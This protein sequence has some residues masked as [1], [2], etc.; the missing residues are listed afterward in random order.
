AHLLEEGRRGG[1]PCDCRQSCGIHFASGSGRSWKCTA[2]GF[3]PLPP[4]ISHGARAP[5]DV[6]SPRPFPPAL[7]SSR[8][9]SHPLASTP[10]GYGTRREIILPSLSATSPSMR[11]AVD[12]GTSLPSPNV[13]CWS[14]Q[15]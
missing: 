10:R 7:R 4:S 11:L 9:P 3:R 2:M 6:H 5:P 12:M 8:P 14:T 1:R 13:S 15:L